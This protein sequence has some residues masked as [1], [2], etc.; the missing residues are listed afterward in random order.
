MS[1]ERK[2]GDHWEQDRFVYARNAGEGGHGFLILTAILIGGLVIAFTPSILKSGN[3]LVPAIC[4]LNVSAMMLFTY[5][6][7][8][9][10]LA[11]FVIDESGI[12]RCRAGKTQRHIS[13][14]EVDCIIITKTVGGRASIVYGKLASVSYT[15]VLRGPPHR[16]LG[17]SFDDSIK[18]LPELLALMNRYIGKHNIPVID[19]RS[20]S[21]LKLSQLP[22]PSN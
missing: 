6:S 10:K 20:G 17:T 4:V 18:R 22:V 7:I 3:I 1:S 16:R 12:N 5:Y 8:E 15:V 2:V 11:D 19:S 14:Q 13:W 9:R 21:D